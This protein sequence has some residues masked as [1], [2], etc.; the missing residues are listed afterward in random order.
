MSILRPQRDAIADITDNYSKG[1]GKRMNHLPDNIT[2]R[3]LHFVTE[4]GVGN[5]VPLYVLGISRPNASPGFQ[6]TNVAVF[7]FTKP[8]R[9]LPRSEE[10][11]ALQCLFHALLTAEP[12]DEGE[13]RRERVEQLEMRRIN[14]EAERVVFQLRRTGRYASYPVLVTS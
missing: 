12:A 13:G 8:E 9:S 4:D 6:G 10:E 11:M 5:K 3:E 1:K 2:E 7:G 14:R